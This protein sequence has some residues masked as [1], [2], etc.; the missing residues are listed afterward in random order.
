MADTRSLYGYGWEAWTKFAHGYGEGPVTVSVKYQT[1]ATVAAAATAVRMWNESAGLPIFSLSDDEAA[2]VIIK[3]GDVPDGTEATGQPYVGGAGRS[4]G[5]I[6]V[7]LPLVQVPDGWYPD[8]SAPE[9]K[10]YAKWL[11]SAKYGREMLSHTFAHEFGHTI[12]FDHPS[13]K[14]PYGRTDEVMGSG[15]YVAA[16]EAAR[17]RQVTG[18]QQQLAQHVDAVRNTTNDAA[19]PK[20]KKKPEPIDHSAQQMRTPT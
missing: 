2:D 9:L 4:R 14:D 13:V 1:P 5:R 8:L 16:D 20:K 15:S 19:P 7:G 10:D 12:G 17:A 11:E 6:N 18:T 3:L